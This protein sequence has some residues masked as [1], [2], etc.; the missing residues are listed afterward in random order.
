MAL[1]RPIIS[2]VFIYIMVQTTGVQ[3]TSA[4]SKESTH[5]LAMSE[6]ER[7]LQ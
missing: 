4:T 3:L 6:P 5:S 1:F 2:K 7:L